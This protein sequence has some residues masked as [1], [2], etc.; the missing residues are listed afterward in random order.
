MN[1]FF[2]ALRI[3]GQAISRTEL[4]AQL[5][6]LPRGL[7]FESVSTGPFAGTWLSPKH[8]LRPLSARRRACVVVGDA[9]LDNRAELA[10]LGGIAD[11]EASDLEV[12]AAAIDRIGSDA[13]PRIE[14]DFSFVYWDARA[15]K[16][17]A[18]RDAFG[19]KPL[20]Y[21]R[22]GSYLLLSS[23]LAPLVG[24]EKL[25]HEYLADLLIGLPTASPRTVWHGTYAVEPGAVLVQRGSVTAQSR[26][27][28]PAQ[29]EPNA[30]ISEADATAQFREL[31]LGAVAGRISE[32]NVWSQLSGGLDSSSIVS[33]AE[34]Q[35]RH[36]SGRGLAGSITV[37]DSLGD[38]DE[39]AFSDAVLA[40]YPMRNQEVRDY[41]PW[42]NDH[43]WRPPRTD[44]PSPLFPFYARDQKSIDLVRQ[45]GARVMLSG[46]G[47]DH[48]LFGT[49]NYMADMLA[50]GAVRGA[51]TEALGWAIA[52][53]R[54]F[55]ST[56]HHNALLP[57]LDQSGLR[58]RAGLT[59]RWIKGDFAAAHGIG[60][61]IAEAA[62]PRAPFG[63][64]YV[65]HTSTELRRVANWVQRGPFEDQL[66]MRYPF[67]HRPL[68][69]FA[70]SLPISMKVRPGTRKWIL[71][72][73]MRGILPE[74]VR[75]RT[76]KGGM[77]ARIL[78]T[79]QHEAGLV[80]ELTHDPLLGQMGCVD[81]DELK[82]MVE[83]ARQ[84]EH[85]H[86]VHLFSVLALE[87][88]LRARADVWPVGHQAQ[89]AA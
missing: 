20:F 45:T 18:A 85:R 15:Q 9:R 36:R 3:D 43:G 25:D 21:R 26:Y 51:L 22:E 27:W 88:W 30:V 17:L 37:V 74:P 1:T 8:S 71:R 42:R 76:S 66:E 84:G 7:E 11:A 64:L 19:V 24:D 23:R 78:W 65:T 72:E 73:A 32:D 52:A 59:P 10:T 68:V 35:R 50:G 83:T 47:S 2:C 69:E 28:D 48:Y 80:R 34:W 63:K 12:I 40:Q 54:S 39:T 33:I 60:E 75:T 29:F 77:D 57:L 86:T 6:R 61:R 46:L 87:S 41:W 5:A 67:L 13:I 81:V 49:L 14:G 55:W 58:R 44:E 79:L 82:K 56:A 89:S 4:F 38:G 62:S 16:I 31:L 53:R 70:L